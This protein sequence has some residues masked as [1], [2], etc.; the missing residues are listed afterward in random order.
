[1]PVRSY[2]VVVA[3]HRYV[4]VLHYYIAIHANALS[5]Y[6]VLILRSSLADV[7]YN[8]YLALHCNTSPINASYALINLLAWCEHKIHTTYELY[9][10]AYRIYIAISLRIVH[11]RFRITHRPANRYKRINTLRTSS[12]QIHARIYTHNT[13][14]CQCTRD[15]CTASCMRIYCIIDSLI[16]CFCQHTS[17][18]RYCRSLHCILL[19]LHTSV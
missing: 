8:A 2:I 4:C 19:V 11:H 1:M 13:T 15:T 9:S 10:L 17:T 16:L 7:R 12:D 18:L 6:V 14:N 5:I 3:S